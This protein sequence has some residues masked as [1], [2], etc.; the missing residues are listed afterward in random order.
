MAAN[1]ALNKRQWKLFKNIFI[2]NV[3]KHMYNF[4]KNC[5]GSWGY[6]VSIKF[7]RKK[8]QKKCD[9]SYLPLIILT[10]VL[11]SIFS[12]HIFQRGAVAPPT[13]MEGH[14]TLNLLHWIVVYWMSSFYWYQNK[15]HSVLYDVTMTSKSGT[16]LR[17]WH[18]VCKI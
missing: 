8:R 2:H 12:E 18:F 1:W 13:I 5:L 3:N 14:I 11:R 15:Y 10:L 17:N 9:F 7:W 6:C 16:A 4:E